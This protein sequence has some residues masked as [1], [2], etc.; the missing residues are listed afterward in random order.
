MGDWGMPQ[1]DWIWSHECRFESDVSAAHVLIDEVLVQLRLLNWS[2][3]AIFAV[4]MAM[5][6]ALVNAIEHGNKMDP[7]KMVDF[8]CFLKHD[9]IRIEVEDEGEGFAPTEL[10][11][12]RDEEYIDIPSGRGVLLIHGFMSSVEYNER[13]NRIVMEKIL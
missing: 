1:P 9:K 8:A 12:P 11:D 13:G 2:D 10:P 7:K 5:E 6:E 3:K 4:N